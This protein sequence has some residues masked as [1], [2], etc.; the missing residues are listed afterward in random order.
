MICL[1]CTLYFF[2]YKTEKRLYF[3]KTT[4]TANHNLQALFV[5][6]SIRMAMRLNN[7]IPVQQYPE[8]SL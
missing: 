8:R 5:L 1:A 7:A 6:T 2:Y 4:Q 3:V